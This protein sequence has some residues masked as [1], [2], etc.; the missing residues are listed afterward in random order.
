MRIDVDVQ[1][2][3]GQT[4]SKLA[5]PSRPRS[6]KS[7]DKGVEE[8]VRTP[9]FVMTCSETSADTLITE[10]KLWLFEILVC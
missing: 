1:E 5:V 2:R 7:L 6:I 8:R 3:D 4:E 9:G 10:T